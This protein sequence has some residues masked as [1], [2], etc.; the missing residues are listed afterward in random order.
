MVLSFGKVSPMA[1]RRELVR[2]LSQLI[3]AAEGS[4]SVA[5]LWLE[6]ASAQEARFPDGPLDLHAAVAD[7]DMEPFFRVHESFLKAAGALKEHEDEKAVNDGWLCRFSMAGA[8]AG[9]GGVRGIFSIER[10]SLLAKRFRRALVPLV[11]KSG[12]QLRFVMTFAKGH[13]AG[14]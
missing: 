9:S 5:A 14:T 12:G 13:E 10:K 3:L 8:G 6:G 11:D 2:V 1:V 7:P 4:P